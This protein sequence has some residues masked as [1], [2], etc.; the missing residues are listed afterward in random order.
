M[1]VQ[2]LQMD[3]QKAMVEH[4]QLE[5]QF[6]ES[7]I[8]KE[9]FDTLDDGAK[10]YKLVGPVLLPQD[11]VEA[12]VNVDKRL[13]FITTQKSQLADKIEKLQNDMH[14]KQM[15]MKE[16]QIRDAIDGNGPQK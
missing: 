10:I 3:L 11:K 1:D 7:R 16:Q 6:Q 13:E 4:Q 8:V 12:A 15:E 5:L 2:T 14:A 9:E